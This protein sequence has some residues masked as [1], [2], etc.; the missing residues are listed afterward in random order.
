[1]QGYQTIIVN[2]FNCQTAAAVRCAG[3]QVSQQL[4][5]AAV[6]LV[7][8]NGLEHPWQPQQ[9][10]SPHAGSNVLTSALFMH[11]N[12][13]RCGVVHSLSQGAAPKQRQRG[14]GGC[15]GTPTVQGLTGVAAVCSRCRP[16][17]RA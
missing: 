4:V 11:H 12:G 7:C 15:R 1:M 3:K 5:P 10:S 2:P 13:S 17:R 16:C 9:P 8:N 6:L 14:G